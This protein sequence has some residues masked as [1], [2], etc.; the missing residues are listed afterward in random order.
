MYGIQCSSLG[1][2]DRCSACSHGHRR[3]PSVPPQQKGGLKSWETMHTTHFLILP[4]RLQTCMRILFLVLRLGQIYKSRKKYWEVQ[5]E[6]RETRPKVKAIS[7]KDNFF[8]R[9]TKKWLS[10]LQ[11]V[12]WVFVCV[13]VILFVLH[14]LCKRLSYSHGHFR[15]IVPKYLINFV[16]LSLVNLVSS[17]FCFF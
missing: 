3:L 14:C 15:T 13:W 6:G 11:F 16:I 2:G 12:G 17:W 1:Y 10:F 8:D 7:E 5:L 9:G 4:F